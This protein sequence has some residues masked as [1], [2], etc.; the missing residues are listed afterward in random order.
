M[1]CEAPGASA[2]ASD[3]EAR[4]GAQTKPPQSPLDRLKQRMPFRVVKDKHN[5]SRRKADEIYRAA[6]V[7][8]RRGNQS[9]AIAKLRLA[10][11]FDEGN[12]TY[13]ETLEKIQGGGAESPLSGLGDRVDSMKRA[14]LMKALGLCEECIE[15][16]RD[17][18]EP[19]HLAAR[20]SVAL[21]SYDRAQEFAERAIELKRDEG[22]FHAA[23]GRALEGQSEWTRAMGAFQEAVRLAPEDDD[24]G[25]RLAGIKWRTRSTSGEQK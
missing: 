9:E 25:R 23:L 10:L 20:V 14:E 21:G 22:S 12:Q 6:L 17:D 19:S 2:A 3:E 24:S 16:E 15:N 18:P 8:L 13:R 4:T 11:M 7:S 5:D 1:G